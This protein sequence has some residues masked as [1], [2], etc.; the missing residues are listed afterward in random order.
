[1]YQY[2]EVIIKQ[3]PYA[4]N[5]KQSHAHAYQLLPFCGEALPLDLDEALVQPQELSAVAEHLL[6]LGNHRRR[7][8]VFFGA[9]RTRGRNGLQPGEVLLVHLQKW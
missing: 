8:I 3:L 7:L 4:T 9:A 1:M 5:K 6:Q 2:G